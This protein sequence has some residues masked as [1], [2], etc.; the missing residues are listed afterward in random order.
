[1]VLALSDNSKNGYLQVVDLKTKDCLKSFNSD[2]P[3]K[4]A[5]LQRF[6]DLY[7]LHPET[8][9]EKAL[10]DDYR[11]QLALYSVILEGSEMS[12]PE[13]ERRIILPTA[14]SWEHLER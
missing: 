1:M 10:M 8:L 7:S 14:I 13:D 6:D 12:K 4:G 2:E 5:P 11:L 9:A 3:Q